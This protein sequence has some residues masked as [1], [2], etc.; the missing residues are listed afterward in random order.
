MATWAAGSET[1]TLAWSDGTSTGVTLKMSANPDG[2]MTVRW[3]EPLT[4]VSSV[5]HLRLL[6]GGNGTNP[7]GQLAR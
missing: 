4:H 3:G 7:V 2:S 1:P 6:H 5:R